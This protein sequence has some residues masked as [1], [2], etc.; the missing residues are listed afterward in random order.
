MVFPNPFNP[1][2]AF[3]GVLKFDNVPLDAEVKIFTLT[4]E[5]VGKYTGDG[6]RITWDGKNAADVDVVSG[7]YLY[8][9]TPKE[10]DKTIAKI[11]LVR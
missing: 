7:I 4:G 9:V 5:L 3:E 1:N 6:S 8:V 10:G 2:T 11:F